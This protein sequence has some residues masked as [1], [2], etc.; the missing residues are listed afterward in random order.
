MLVVGEHDIANP[1]EVAEQ[2]AHLTTAG[3]AI[4]VSGAGHDVHSSHP[5]WLETTAME[6]LAALSTAK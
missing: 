1:I 5:D 6:W 2:Y 4:Q 3:R